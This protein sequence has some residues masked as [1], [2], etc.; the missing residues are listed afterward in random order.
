MKACKN[1]KLLSKKDDRCSYCG[2]LTSTRWQGYVIIRDPK[3]SQIAKKLNITKPGK[4]AL[5]VQR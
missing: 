5:K 1:C 2:E 4:Y 3:R